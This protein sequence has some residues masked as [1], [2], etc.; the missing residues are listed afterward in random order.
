MMTSLAS[1]G[2]RAGVAIGGLS[3]ERI[4]LTGVG[5]TYLAVLTEPPYGTASVKSISLAIAVLCAGTLAS[6]E[7]RALRLRLTD[8]QLVLMAIAAFALA[9]SMYAL[10]PWESLRFFKGQ[11]L[12]HLLV[13]GLLCGLARPEDH[14]HFLRVIAVVVAL[15]SVVGIVGFF[16]GTVAISDEVLGRRASSVFPSYDRAA[17][18]VARWS[19]ALVALGLCARG[20]RA[21]LGWWVGAAVCYFFVLLTYTRATYFAVL[22]AVGVL[23]WWARGAR[24]TVRAALALALAV[25]VSPLILGKTGIP[26]R[27]HSVA[28]IFNR[29]ETAGDRDLLLQSSVSMF[30]DHPV[31]GIGYGWYNFRRLYPLYRRPEARESVLYNCHNLYLQVLLEGGIVG[32]FPYFL[33]AGVLCG[34]LRAQYRQRRDSSRSPPD[35]RDVVLLA[36]LGNLTVFA[37]YSFTAVWFHAEGGLDFWVTVAMLESVAAGGREV[38]QAEPEGAPRLREIR[39]A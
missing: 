8:L 27:F 15:L 36:A 11:L 4:R 16:T 39:G 5:A 31:I 21:A 12:Q 34:R 26:E 29:P 7:W 13:L 20:F 38:A 18:Y 17:I 25:A 24:A 6:R 23:L 33:L 10:D 2:R 32:A 19:L 9:G 14:R 28:H 1:L 22:A 35:A 37:L 30:L 3:V